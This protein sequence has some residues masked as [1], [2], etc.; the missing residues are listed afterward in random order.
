MDFRIN[1]PPSPTTISSSNVYKLPD[2]KAFRMAEYYAIHEYDGDVIT[3]LAEQAEQK[4][5]TGALFT[6]GQVCLLENRAALARECFSTAAYKYA[7][8]G[9]ALELIKMLYQDLIT[10]QDAITILATR[11]NAPRE[12]ED[13]TEEQD[14]MNKLELGELYLSNI[15]WRSDRTGEAKQLLE[16][17]TLDSIPDKYPKMQQLFAA[18]KTHSSTDATQQISSPHR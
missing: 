15:T 11:I 17:I 18:I 12:E 3:N 2:Q 14:N 6:I 9:A 4:G 5:V 10:D 7:S 8:R 13:I 16:Q 1:R